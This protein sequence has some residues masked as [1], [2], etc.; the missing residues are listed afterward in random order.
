[1]IFDP[2]ESDDM[3]R[4]DKGM[5][6]K[7]ILKIL[8]G[9][10]TALLILSIYVLCFSNSGVHITNTTNATDYKWE[11]NQGKSKTDE[12]FAWITLD[13]DGFNNRSIPDSIDILIMGSSH[14]E[15]V[16]ISQDENVG[17]LLSE[18]IKDKNI[19][20]IGVS[21]HTIYTCVQNISDAVNYYSPSDY[22]ILET[23][24][25]LLNKESMLSVVDNE[26][27]EIQ[28]YDSG[29]VY[30]LQKKLPVVKAVYKALDDWRSADSRSVAVNEET[31][32]IDT[33]YTDILSQ[34]LSKAA[35][36]VSTSGAKLIIFY[37]PTT[38]IDEEGDLINTTDQ[39]A[40]SAFQEACDK[41]DI[42]FV[43]M[44]PD[45]ERMYEEEHILAHGF[46]NTAV[47]TGHL[48]K[49]G[50]KAIAERLAEVIGGEK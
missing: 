4:T 1:M 36:G 5:I 39:E 3:K 46:I 34:F 17:T 25:I 44:T 41:N 49:Y 48:N 7:Y 30:L 13:E 43:D 21:G 11:A 29:I 32:K 2:L 35:S 20:N 18:T 8:V 15:A 40:L 27:P 37:H 23:S 33:E 19:Y 50:H 9:G 16:N 10:S 6:P 12:G 22:V 31:R 24:E 47:G 26:Y 42:I 45:F 14:M 28:S 38:E